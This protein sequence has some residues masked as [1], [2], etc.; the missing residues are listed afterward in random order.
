MKVGILL[1]HPIQY[2]SPLF[3]L[4]KEHVDLHVFYG[5][6]DS[7]QL[8][9][10]AGFG[11][12]FQWDIDLLSGYSHSFLTNISKQ[13]GTKSFRDCD[14]PEI[15]EIIRDG[16]FDVFIVF[17]WYLKSY[18][19]AIRACRAYHIPVLVRGDSQLNP[20]DSL[21]KRAAK[22]ITH[23]LALR[24]FD[25]F[26][27][28]GCRNREYLRHYGV[29]EDRIFRVPH[30]VD[31]AWFASRAESACK[32]RERIRREW[33]ADDSTFVV[34]FAGKFIFKKRPL[35]I[36]RALHILGEDDGAFVA[37]FVGAGELESQL[38]SESDSLGVRTHFA[39]FRNQTEMPM[40]YANADVL[41]LPSDA[42]ETWGLVVNEGMAC[43]LPAVVSEDVGCSPDLIDSGRTG[44]TFPTRQVPW[45]ARRLQELRRARRTVDFSSA[46]VEKVSEYSVQFALQATIAAI[47]EVH[48]LRKPC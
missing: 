1:S 39:G 16:G 23:R 42:S 22:Q 46:A 7:P 32:E 5:M 17:G 28:V 21:A 2:Y 9:A 27:S 43:G 34:L 36:V 10:G 8:Q 25:G 19:Q 45:L 35:D 24:H 15:A 30:F 14:T 26:L 41:A 38:R 18:W 37:L 29:S 44:F 12:E 47:A 6:K 3:R 31:N 48:R 11:V 20:A 40:Y 33:G 4:L 13:P